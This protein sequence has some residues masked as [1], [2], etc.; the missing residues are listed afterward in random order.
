MAEREEFEPAEGP[1]EISKL[2]II[3]GMSSPAIPLKNPEFGTGF[4]H[5][6]HY[7]VDFARLRSLG[8]LCSRMSPSL[9][10]DRRPLATSART[11]YYGRVPTALSSVLR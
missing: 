2:L 1:N 9:A 8:S 5:S 6:R 11:P 7:A 10:P 4:G 3:S